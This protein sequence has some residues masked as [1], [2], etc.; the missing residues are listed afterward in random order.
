MN[1][2]LLFVVVS[3]L[4]GGGWYVSQNYEIVGIDQV[5]LVPKDPSK[6][7][8]SGLRPAKAGA[9]I[10]IAS[11]NIQTLGRSKL[12]KPQ[13]VERIADII[14]R[15]DIVAVQEVRSKHQDIVPRLVEY[16]N[17]D[18][19]H[20]DYVLG[21]RV[22]RTAQKEQYAFL[23]DTETI[24]VDRLAVYTIEDP[25]DLMHRPPLVAPFRVRG[26][27]PK[28]AFTFTL[29]NLHTDPDEVA[30][31]IRWLP[32]LFRAVL[33]DGR[34]ED[35][36]ILLGDFN[37]DDRK[38]DGALK[39]LPGALVTLQA[40]PTNTRMNAQYDNIIVML[41]A[42]REYTGQVEV[43]DILRTFNLTMDEAIAVSDHNP[44]WASFHVREGGPDAPVV[45][46]AVSTGNTKRR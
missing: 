45:S 25:A 7:S 21:P 32:D 40:T 27:D 35:D 42:T 8:A 18:G 26:V 6:R 15:F 10:R 4:V 2:A 13:V 22:G 39:T 12:S 5:K 41:P 29:V 16:V 36:V 11:F 14:R 43:F 17:A 44:V 31:E 9:S 46:A 30:E 23:F 19:R 24:E 1:K 28:E 33:G 20:Y 37:A 38:L 3:L 34:G